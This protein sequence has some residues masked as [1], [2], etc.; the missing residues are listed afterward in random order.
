MATP[1]NIQAPPVPT[2][3]EAGWLLDMPKKA[4]QLLCYYLESDYSQTSLLPS[5]SVKSFQWT[6]QRWNNNPDEII[7]AVSA[8]L[9]SL[10]GPYFESVSV[11]VQAAVPTVGIHAGKDTFLDIRID[12]TVA[13]NGE[14]I[15]LGKAI[16][17]GNAKILKVI[18]IHQA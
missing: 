10:M 12:V 9:N 14:R 18:P 5:G 15:S 17:T 13:Q 11:D 6:L 3:S 7:S 2:L 1:T 4:D 16:S 8:D